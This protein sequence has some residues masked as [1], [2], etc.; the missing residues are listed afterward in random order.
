MSGPGR[1]E[2]YLRQKSILLRIFPAVLKDRFKDVLLGGRWR[3]SADCSP[4][5][6]D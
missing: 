3:I 2:E 4:D 5:L 6:S 1:Q